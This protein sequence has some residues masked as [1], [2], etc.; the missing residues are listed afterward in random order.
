MHFLVAGYLKDGADKKLIEHAQEFNEHLGAAAS[1]VVMAGVLRDTSNTRIGY[2]AI[3]RADCIETAQRWFDDSPFLRAGFYER[4][5]IFEYQN[6]VG[7][8]D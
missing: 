5:E 4:S 1:D 6:E 3:I 2:M 8:F 7:P